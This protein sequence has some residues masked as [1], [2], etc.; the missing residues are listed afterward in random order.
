[1]PLLL[2]KHY[3]QNITAQDLS[4]AELPSEKHC[5][6]FASQKERRDAFEAI[7]TY[8]LNR[9]NLKREPDIVAQY[10]ATALTDS[11]LNFLGQPMP[12]VTLGD[13]PAVEASEERFLD[14][15]FIAIYW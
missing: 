12:F 7:A 5:N 1:M 4:E 15:E 2:A 14:S 3:G 11:G 13:A 10:R 9:F 6:S 8:V